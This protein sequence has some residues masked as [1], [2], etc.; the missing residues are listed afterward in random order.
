MSASIAESLADAARR[1][2]PGLRAFGTR[3]LQGRLVISQ[4][5]R[6]MPRR[7]D[8]SKAAGVSAVVNWVIGEEGREQRWQL[9]I[10]EGRCL[11]SRRLERDPNLTITIGAPEFLDLVTGAATGPAMFTSGKLRLDGDLMMAVRLPALFKVPAA[12][13]S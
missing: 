2:P 6:M 8:R 3:G 13:R 9:V 1:A 4:I 10:R 11:T 7:F 5:F 12:R